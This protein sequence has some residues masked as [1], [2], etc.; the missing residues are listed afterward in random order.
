MDNIIDVKVRASATGR[1][2]VRDLRNEIDG[3]GTALGGKVQEDAKA[4][5]AALD[6]L[7]AQGAAINNVRA[8]K[9]ESD[10]LSVELA[11]AQHAVEQLSQTLPDAASA[12]SRLAVAEV[13]AK[14]AVDG[15]SRDLDEQR[16][17]LVAL[18][19]EYTGAS[20]STDAYREANAQ[21]QV[22]V[23]EGR[24]Y[25]RE[26]EEALRQVSQ[27]SSQAVQA[28][29]ALAASYTEAGEALVRTRAQVDAQAAALSAASTEAR[30]LG[31]DTDKLA[32]AERGLAE[33][34]ERAVSEGKAFVSIQRSMQQ[35]SE[36]QA[37]AQ[38]AAQERARQAANA[39]TAAA[40]ASAEAL[41]NAYGELGVRS[42]D[43]LRQEIERVRGAMDTVRNTAGVSGQEVQRAFTAG[44]AQ[45]RELERELRAATGQM[46]LA[47]RAAGA[48]KN[49]MGQFAAGSLLADGITSIVG[50]IKDL[51]REFIA[52]NVQMEG[53]RRGLT[54]VYG[55][56]QTAASQIDVLRGAANRSGIAMSGIADSFV[57]F[58]AATRSANI[59][60]QVTNDL[61]AAVT[62][63]GSTLGLS[64]ERVTLVLDAL[65]QMASKGVVSMEELRQQLGE[66]LPGALSLSAKGLGITDQ[67]LIK[68][69][70]SGKLA[71][72]DFFPALTKGLQEMQGSTDTLTGNWGRLLNVLNQTS[73][74]IGDA[75]GVKVMTVALKALLVV[76][77][78]IVVPVQAFVEVVNL[79]GRAVY[80]FYE[81]LRGRGKEAQEEFRKEVDKSATRMTGLHKALDDAING[82]DKQ[83]A[84][85]GQNA[86]AHAR[87][88]SAILANAAAQEKSGAAATGAGVAYVQ[89]M[90]RLAENATATEAATTATEKLLK[91]KQDEG[92]ANVLTAQLTGDASKAL[93]ANAAAATATAAASAALQ[94][95]RE[96]ELASTQAA[97]AAIN[98]QRDAAGQLSTAKQSQ[99]D[100]L[101]NVLK[102][103]LSEVEASRTSTLEMS[104]QALAAQAASEAYADNSLQVDAYR[105]AMENSRVVA[106][107]L[108]QR[109]IA[110][111]AA[112][113]ELKDK[114]ETG[115]ITQ[116]FYDQAQQNLT[117][118]KEALNKAT[119]DAAKF[120]NLYRDAVA[121][122]V[123]AT[124]RKARAD[125]AHLTVNEA[126]VKSQQ[127]HYETMARQA[128]AL[129]DEAQATYYTVEAKTKQIEA[130][131]L[132]TQIKNLELAADK[133][134]LEIQLAA[135]S[136]QDALYA[137]KKQELEIRLELIKAKQI[138][139]N[140]SSEVIK[141]IEDEIT[142][143]RNLNG[144]RG[145]S[146]NSFNSRGNGSNS[147]SGGNQGAGGGNISSPSG[148]SG[149]GQRDE[150]RPSNERQKFFYGDGQGRSSG[151]GQD[152]SGRQVKSSFGDNREQRLTG[153]NATDNRLMFDLRD[154][155]AAGTLSPQDVGDLRAVV[156][157]LRQNSI[158]NAQV[159]R[160]MPGAISLE[161][162]RDDIAWQATGKRFQQAI[163][164]FEGQ[165]GQATG[166]GLQAP[167]DEDA[168]PPRS[169]RTVNL[170][171]KLDNGKQSPRLSLRTDEE[172][173]RNAEQFFKILKDGRI[174]SG[175]F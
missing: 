97:I 5:A 71:T 152:D 174:N 65:G 86:Q 87:T 49:T 46:T 53:M 136:P 59:P 40:K 1:E 83:S 78:V 68:L 69:V 146:V 129:G 29:R 141:G 47:D 58:S 134:G 19:A 12:V 37:A 105:Q 85:L 148:G 77:G 32:E 38:A 26:Q 44:T 139:A 153:Q 158:Q 140:A 74:A 109:V 163:D 3:L 117:A 25:L 110:Q 63:A 171:L 90:V 114:L 94:M 61:F 138:E 107:A 43:Q 34:I 103:Q 79:A 31:I 89:Q 81:S 143:L 128:K 10:A 66:S 101:N 8:L 150:Q 115:K 169:E 20:R 157:A 60:L 16:Q 162:Q 14:E 52:S 156:A 106:E 125:A 92:K 30:T 62:R 173:A 121:D 54:A 70:E 113:D 36:A 124:D 22:S 42:A 119:G 96:R 64:S 142:A 172:G 27:L 127:A 168:Q 55:S 147:N 67:Q 72:E 135:L 39:A 133:A 7:G 151:G 118:T 73:T 167:Q 45:V 15:A 24:S 111:T 170:N 100:Q 144:Q 126:L 112:L 17:A 91:A 161:G 13:Q 165:G 82:S 2:D 11:Q 98:G 9:N 159:R 21:L 51:G 18:R 80:G 93:D 76:V 4:A 102:V 75:G 164:R 132:A 88:A 28:E 123:A 155:L 175:K 23:R 33:A 108:E 6:A 137:Q 131:K 149:G 57:R 145:G 166:P 104:R 99:L 130:I 41:R 95:A 160:H 116:E 154:K 122:S 120:E 35:A 84:A 50:K 48:F 56:V